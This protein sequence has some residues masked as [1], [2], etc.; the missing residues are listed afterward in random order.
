[1][2]Q[3]RCLQLLEINS[4]L[5]LLVAHVFIFII[6]EIMA[7]DSEVLLCQWIK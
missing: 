6:V 5:Q 2:R 7:L 4:A 3:A 1:L